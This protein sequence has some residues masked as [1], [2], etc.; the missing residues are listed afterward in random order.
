MRYAISYVSTA[1][2][3]LTDIEIE[4]VLDF[5]KNWNNDHNITGILLFS[6]GNF[7]QV[8]EDEKT[9][10]QDLFE[11]ISDDSRHFNVIRIFGKEIDDANFEGYSANFISI[12]SQFRKEDF[13]RYLNQ[14]DSLNPA[15][16]TSV[17]YIL[18]NF[19]EGIK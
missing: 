3:K 13:G 6:E 11:R 15:I 5:S 12:D 17:Q 4:K 14:V 8:L 18:K 10:L 1:S 19:S 16:R 9:I 2:E 7:F